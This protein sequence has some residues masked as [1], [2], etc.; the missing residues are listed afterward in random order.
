MHFFTGRY[1]YNFLIVDLKYERNKVVWADG[2]PSP[3]SKTDTQDT[4]Y[5]KSGECVSLGFSCAD[6]SLAWQR[7]RCN[8]D[9]GKDNVVGYVCKVPGK[10]F[11]AFHKKSVYINIEKQ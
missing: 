9:W 8:V 3:F 2:S 10:Y 4:D 7:R 6:N 1:G 11:F 5:E